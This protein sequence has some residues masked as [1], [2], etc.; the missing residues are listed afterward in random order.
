MKNPDVAGIF[1][2]DVPESP[3]GGRRLASQ[4]CSLGFY[5]R[6]FYL[7]IA[8]RKIVRSMR[9]PPARQTEETEGMTAA[10]GLVSCCAVAACL[11]SAGVVVLAR[12][13]DFPELRGPYLGQTPPR[14]GVEV[15]APGILKPEH[16]FHSSVVFNSVGTQACWTEMAAGKTFCSASVDGRWTRP[17]PVPFDPEFGVREP[18]FAHGDRRF[19][20][21]SR[22]PLPHDPVDRERIWFVERTATGWSEP[23]VVD[24]VVTAHPTHWQFSFTAGGDLYFTSEIDGVR[25]EQDIYVARR[26][27]GALTE[28]TTAGDAVNSDLREFCPFVAP[29]ES[30]LIFARSV[31]EERGRS[32]LFISFRDASGRWTEAVNMGD[33]VNSEHNET[34]PVV[35]PDGRYFFFLRVSGDVNDVYWTPAEIIESIRRRTVAATTGASGPLGE[36]ELLEGIEGF[37]LAIE[38]QPRSVRQ[39]R[40]H[41]QAAHFLQVPVV[42]R[43]AVVASRYERDNL[44]R[45]YF[46]YGYDEN[47][48]LFLSELDPSLD[49]KLRNH[50]LWVS[51]VKTYS[52]RQLSFEIPVGA[53]TFDRLES[54]QAVSFTCRIAA[55]IR[56]RSVYCC[57]VSNASEIVPEG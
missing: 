4:P 29:D 39:Q 54:G 23:R 1:P 53:E 22:R 18:M 3:A 28:P 11:L 31:P 30:Y 14:S 2:T 16:G 42:V 32:D 44:S 24:K 5:F 56:G 38:G 10:M 36:A 15:F 9:S 50:R 48:H 26:R 33:G 52:T 57:P 25:G 55:L 17:E 43:G 20:Y 40:L 37:E 12:G 27:D 8:Y 34:S 21:L 45:I 6:N 13:P 7:H 41:E 51:V 49:E 35:T 46:G 47:D 19:Y